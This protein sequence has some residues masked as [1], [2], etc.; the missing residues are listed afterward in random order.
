[1]ISA[2]CSLYNYFRD[3]EPSTGR[4]VQ[5]DPV[6]LSAG[7]NTYAYVNARPLSAADPF[8]LWSTDAHNYF[9]RTMFP[10]LPTTLRDAIERGSRTTDNMGYQGACNSH[11]HAMS[12]DCL[13]PQQAREKMCKFV[14]SNLAGY[15]L[16]V[17]STDAQSQN[18]AYFLLGMALH[19]IMDS[20]SPVHR[21]FQRWHTSAAI[22]HGPSPYS[23]EGVEVA[24]QT[25]YRMET[26]DL[27]RRA[28]SGD[29]AICGCP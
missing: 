4:Y 15:N 27:M 25:Q 5:S 7:I 26:L 14:K 29:L 3:Y 6:G 20:T 19:P 10:N 18:S 1:M 9:I 16:L 12:S 28:M 24:R 8:G 21:G 11:M 2:A 13:T 17:G 22:D 23:K